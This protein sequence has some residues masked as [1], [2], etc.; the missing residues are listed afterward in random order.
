[1]WWDTACSSGPFLGGEFIAEF[2]REW[3]VLTTLTALL[4]GGESAEKINMQLKG[5]AQT[6]CQPFTPHS[7]LSAIIS[8]PPRSLSIQFVP[9]NL[10]I[11]DF[12]V[13]VSPVKQ[14]YRCF[15]LIKGTVHPAIMCL[16]SCHFKHRE[17]EMLKNNRGILFQEPIWQK[18]II[19]KVFI[20]FLYMCPWTTKSVIRVFF[21]LLRFIYHL[22]AE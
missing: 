9:L 22:K 12:T 18:R 3:P 8:S 13:T 10:F 2:I 20:Y 21:Y 14:I 7:T 15:S 1:M 6:I 5:L 11:F 17:S 19:I 4:Q 16:S